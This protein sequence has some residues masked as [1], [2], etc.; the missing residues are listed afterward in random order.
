MKKGR[1][2]TMTNGYR[3]IDLEH[4]PRR[5]HYEYYTQ[6][7]RIEFN[8]T[9]RVRVDRFLGFC[10][11]RGYRFYPALICAVTRV[12]NRMENFRMFRD[13]AGEL[14][15]W[16]HVVP[17]YTIFHGDDHTFSDCWSQ[18]TDDFETSYRTITADM[19][20][21]GDRKGIKVREGQPP[22]FYCISCDPWTDFTGF[23]SR[24]TDG[25]PQFFPIVTIGKYVTE[26]GKTTMSVSLMIAHAVCDGYHAG[27][28]FD[29]LQQELDGMGQ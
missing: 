4:W 15:V 22:N 18:C 28:F 19:E 3:K 2:C 12:M 5:A 14:C 29:L 11:E 9:A 16:D 26:Q 21:Y 20:Q 1:F 27:V 6:K 25:E 13:G 24:R 8:I 17:N 23:A 7:L 10:H